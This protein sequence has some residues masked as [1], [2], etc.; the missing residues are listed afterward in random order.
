MCPRWLYLVG[1]AATL[2]LGCDDEESGRD[3][4]TANGASDT[5]MGAGS[6]TGSGG[7][8]GGRS[9]TGGGDAG[10]A[11][12][13][14]GGGGDPGP[15]TA[16]AAATVRPATPLMIGGEAMVPRG[17]ADEWLAIMAVTDRSDAVKWVSGVS[18][19]GALPSA[20]AGLTG[21]RVAVDPDNRDVYVVFTV[22]AVDGPNPMTVE[23]SG[24]DGTVSSSTTTFA[25]A[26]EVGERLTEPFL[27][28]FDADGAP[29]WV[30]RLAQG[31]GTAEC[32]AAVTRA[33][34]AEGARVMVAFNTNN[35]NNRSSGSTAPLT[36]GPG[37]PNQTVYDVP[38]NQRVN[39]TMLLDPEAGALEAVNVLG[40]R[41]TNYG[42]VNGG[43]SF[44]A[45]TM[46]YDE[47]GARYGAAGGISNFRVTDVA[48]GLQ[49]DAPVDVPQ[50]GGEGYRAIWGTLAATDL[51]TQFVQAV[52]GNTS[53][54]FAHFTHPLSDGRILVAAYVASTSNA[55]FSTASEPV[56]AP[57]GQDGTGWLALYQA[58][59]EL[60]WAKPALAGGGELA[61]LDWLSSVD[62]FDDDAIFM[63]GRLRGSPGVTLGS[64]E[65]GE[66]TLGDD[67]S[68][69]WQHGV[70][71]RYERST[72]ALEWARLF[73]QTSTPSATSIRG[74]L[75]RGPDQSLEI[76][77]GAS[78]EVDVAGVAEDFGA[79]Y[80]WV[81]TRFDEA[82]TQLESDV[83]LRPTTGAGIP[84][85]ATDLDPY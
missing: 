10:G 27:A 53:S 79:G 28:K 71:A 69:T 19:S 1:L 9:D 44:P 84:V 52:A 72:G 16:I 60:V 83:M 77:Y 67:V 66:V 41:T 36:L 43:W 21:V 70:L 47:V 45:S 49:G 4:G 73:E 56:V 18:F 48:F 50:P 22:R 46:V 23:L 34:N 3:A 15:R 61:T 6:D 14:T 78:G 37:D 33:V 59:G 55:T 26:S 68:S 57:G 17:G 30:E 2:S 13:D 81:R 39:V 65:P 42:G 64:G 58:D 51:T 24:P 74:T 38:V 76:R 54:D 85:I 82:G 80:A 5:G 11:D 31:D 32:T 29:V 75:F 7:T 62:D 12:A 63:W 8:D 40:D 20:G 25:D 35:L